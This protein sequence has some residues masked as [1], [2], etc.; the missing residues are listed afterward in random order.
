MYHNINRFIEKARA[1]RREGKG[2]GLLSWIS[3]AFNMKKNSGSGGSHVIQG[4]QPSDREQFP[5]SDLAAPP[6]DEQLHRVRLGSVLPPPLVAQDLQD[7]RL[8]DKLLSDAVA[9]VGSPPPAEVSARYDIARAIAKHSNDPHSPPS[10]PPLSPFNTGVPPMTRN[11][12]SIGS[13]P[14]VGH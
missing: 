2:V 1:L 13:L 6:T 10:L 11:E 5:W 9:I 12:Y 4:E 8:R 7:R 3:A 14:K